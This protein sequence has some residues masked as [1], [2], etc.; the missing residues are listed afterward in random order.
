MSARVFPIE[1]MPAI[2]RMI[3][4]LDIARVFDGMSHQEMIAIR[5]HWPL[6]ALPHQIMP[7]GDWDTWLLLGGRGIGKT[8]TTSKAVIQAAME[9]E[10]LCGGIIGIMGRTHTDVRETNVQAQATGILAASPEGFRPRWKPGPGTLTWDNGA[11][12]R[13]FSADTPEAVLGTNAALMVMDELAKYPNGERTVKEIVDLAVRVG[14]ARKIISTTP[15]PLQYLI[16]IAKHPRTIVTRATTYDNPFLTPSALDRYERAYAGT[17]LEREALFGEFLDDIQGA[18]LNYSAI[19]DN[20]VKH[21]PDLVKVAIGVD[22]AVSDSKRGDS[23]GIVAFGVDSRGHGFVLED[24]T[25]KYG[26]SSNEWARVVAKLY[27][28]WEADIVVAE[29]NRGGKMV[30]GVMRAIDP[31]MPV[32]TV[33]ATRGKMTRAQPVAALYQQGRIHHV[34]TKAKEIEALRPLEDELTTWTP[35]DPSPNRLDALVWAA[36]QTMVTETATSPLAYFL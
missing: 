23:T 16:D 5:D 7:D 8:I 13:V 12:A 19:A 26:I 31:A 27:K 14:Q 11:V 24:A 25:G 20:R 22:P 2:Y 28:K 35:G 21:A 4:D 32:V 15:K 18:L 29:I 3:G 9:V 36:T 6:W 1:K 17:R 30:E 33:T 34:G 10:K